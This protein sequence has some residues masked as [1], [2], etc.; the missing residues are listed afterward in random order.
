VNIAS[1][2]AG[3]K[4]RLAT[5]SGLRCYETIPDQF[6]PPAAIV[7][8]PTSIVFDFVYQRAADRMTY[9]IRIL[10]GK[11]TDRSAQERLEKYLDGSGA[12]SVKAAIEGDPSLGGAANVTRVLSAQGL[13]VYDM[14]GVSY[15][16]CDFTVEV[17]C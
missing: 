8:M 15:L 10:V 12:L 11:A 6:S 9:P 4:T 17:I 14:G 7:G 1:V 13:G 16:G 2:R 5:I 3:L